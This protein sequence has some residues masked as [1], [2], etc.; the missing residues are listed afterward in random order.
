[1]A[2]CFADNR[3]FDGARAGL[4][5]GLP[6]RLHV[7]LAPAQILIGQTSAFSGPVA[8]GVKEGT[9]GAKVY[10]DFINDR[11]GVNGQKIELLTLDDKLDA[12]LAAENAQKLIDKGA[13]A[14]FFNRGTP[15]TQAIH[16]GAGQEQG[17]IDRA[18]NRRDAAAQA[19]A[20]LGLQRARHLPAGSR[21]GCAAPAS[22]GPDPHCGA[23]VRRFFR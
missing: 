4:A 23:A 7:S 10:L 14:L 1:M 18:V 12:K 17:A 9:D 21:K 6:G 22:G 20:P 16:A 5:V 13:V 19:G 3:S 11:G 8:S 15:M 2:V